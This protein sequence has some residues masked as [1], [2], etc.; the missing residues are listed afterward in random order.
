[1]MACFAA[2]LPRYQLS[3]LNIADERQA[4]SAPVE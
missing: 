4:I 1:M 3:I 2:G